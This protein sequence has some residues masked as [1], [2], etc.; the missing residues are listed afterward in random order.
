MYYPSAVRYTET[1]LNPEGLFVRLSG[2]S[3]GTPLEYSSGA[4]G[5]VF[6]V[7]VGDRPCALKCFTRHQ[8]GRAEAYRRIVEAL[9]PGWAQGVPYIV[10]F[11]WI[12]DEMTVFGDDDHPT[13]H[14]VVAMEWVEGRS[15]TQAIREAVQ[16]GDRGE[17][18]KLSGAFD[19]LALWLLEQPFAHGD[20]KPDNLIVRQQDGELTMIDYDGL[21]LPE[22][23]GERAREIGTE[24][25]RHP[26]R[27]E[28]EFGKHID[29][30][31]VSLLSLGLQA[32][33]R[34][35][36]LYD[37]FG[38]RS[39]LLFDPARLTAG[40]CP[41]YN[42]L[43]ETELAADPLFGWLGSGADRFAGLAEALTAHGAGAGRGTTSYD[44]VGEPGREGIR[45]VKRD[46][47]YGFIANDET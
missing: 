9:S 34:W 26:G 23:A 31:S 21:Y 35:P 32:L 41:A 17:L 47:K 1:I 30:F 40:A 7:S 20:L 36:E 43:K 6:R 16:A 39:G 28:R 2:L 38:E 19:R 13:V 10:P 33:V 25:F 3:A 24:G 42:F 4:Y 44:Y 5:V 8:P 15:L 18:E 11:R 22:M 27:S 46:G 37:R 45:L 29:D 14:S 12:D